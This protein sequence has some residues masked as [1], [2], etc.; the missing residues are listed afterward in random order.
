MEEFKI[1]GLT[2]Q[3]VINAINLF[4]RYDSGFIIQEVYADEDFCQPKNKFL[5]IYGKSDIKNE[6]KEV[7]DVIFTICKDSNKILDFKIKQKEVN[8]N[9]RI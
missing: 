9:G 5:T 2:G 3:D 6:R 4:L 8:Y 1:M 7:R